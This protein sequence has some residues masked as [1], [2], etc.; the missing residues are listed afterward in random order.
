MLDVFWS[1]MAVLL[2]GVLVAMLLDVTGLLD[3]TAWRALVAVLLFGLAVDLGRL[4][5]NGRVVRDGLL[6]PATVEAG[7]GRR[8]RSG[9][10]IRHRQVV[11]PGG[12]RIR[13]RVRMPPEAPPARS[14]TACWCIRT[15]HGSGPPSRAC[16]PRAGPGTRGSR[17][18]G[19]HAAAGRRHHRGALGG[20]VAGRLLVRHL[21]ARLRAV[22]TVRCWRQ[23]WLEEVVRRC[24]TAGLDIDAQ[25]P[26]DVER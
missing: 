13:D 22:A 10:R 3:P 2:L 9:A 23:P 17:A 14:P 21:G 1:A 4:V 12:D 16:A 20:R 19:G 18:R 26:R 24:E 15:S 11:H 7:P 8:T 5:R 25:L 6:V